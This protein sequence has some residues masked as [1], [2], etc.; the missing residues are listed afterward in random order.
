[1]FLS[2]NG[3]SRIQWL[4]P[5]PSWYVDENKIVLAT[6]N[7]LVLLLREEVQFFKNNKTNGWAIFIV[8]WY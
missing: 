2:R 3:V 5:L 8:Q 1:M 6:Q 7:I 4:T